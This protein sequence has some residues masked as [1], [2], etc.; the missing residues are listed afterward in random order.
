MHCAQRGKLVSHSNHF[1]PSSHHTDQ[2]IMKMH[3]DTAIEVIMNTYGHDI[4]RFIF[5]YMKN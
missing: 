5:T 2:D 4:K 3:P 1:R